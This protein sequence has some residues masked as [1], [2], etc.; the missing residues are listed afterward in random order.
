M[1][2][3]KGPEEHAANPP[4]T[5]KAVKAGDRS[6][7]LTTAGGDVIGYYKTKKDTLAARDDPQGHYPMLW[8]K[9]RR[10]YAGEQVDNWRPYAQIKAEQERRRA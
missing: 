6:W 9:E 10:W 1:S 2:L 7:R 8:E 3:F 5:W 4:E